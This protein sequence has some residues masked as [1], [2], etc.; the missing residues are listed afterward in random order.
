MPVLV[1]PVSVPVPVPVPVEEVVSSS[2]SDAQNPSTGL[3]ESP[4]QQL[5]SSMHALARSPASRH[6]STHEAAPI[7]PSPPS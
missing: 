2:A 7:S 4:E 5:S 6:R 3:H 1:V